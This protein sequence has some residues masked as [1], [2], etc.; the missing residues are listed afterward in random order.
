MAR[1]LLLAPLLSLLGCVPFPNILSRSASVQPPPG[2]SA[3]APAGIIG[4][5]VPSL[6]CCRSS[7]AGGDRTLT[8]PSPSTAAL[9]VAGRTDAAVRSRA[10]RSCG[11]GHGAAGCWGEHG[12][13]PQGVSEAGGR[14]AYTT[15]E[16]RRRSVVTR[17]L[18][19]TGCEPSR[20]IIAAFICMYIPSLCGCHISIAA[21]ERTLTAPSPSTA[22]LNV[23][24][25]MDAA[26]RSRAKRSLGGGQGAAGCWGAKF[27]VQGV[28][29]AGGPKAADN[30]SVR[31]SHERTHGMRTKCG[32]YSLYVCAIP[33]LLS[34]QH[35]GR[36]AHL[37][38][39]PASPCMP[40][41]HLMLQK[42]FKP[43]HVAAEKGQTAVVK[44]LLNAWVQKAP[45][46]VC[47]WRMVPRL[48]R[49]GNTV[50]SGAWAACHTNSRT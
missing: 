29:E 26:V 49:A 33:L 50:C 40:P 10:K 42:G 17:T 8:A 2:H 38:T 14:K 11:W 30:R 28:S 9:N 4:M 13:G 15:S 22:A 23:A 21:G 37:N 47:L 44:A 24:G 25:W 39:V 5:Y 7:I 12:H 16:G 36:A 35:C 19:R 46:K 45:A 34:Q 41:P 43:L 27:L 1:L 3:R 32:G 31:W 6:C 18:A 20:T 48:R